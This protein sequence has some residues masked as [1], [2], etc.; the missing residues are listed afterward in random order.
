M[1]RL[2]FFICTLLC[3]N[4]LSAQLFWEGDLRY[5]VTGAGKVEVYG[6]NDSVTSVN[7]P[8][9]VTHTWKHYSSDC[10]CYITDSVRTYNVTSIGEYGLQYCNIAI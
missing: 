7:I 9:S 1:K 4:L 8:S 2:L 3:A 10:D 5:R 6:Y